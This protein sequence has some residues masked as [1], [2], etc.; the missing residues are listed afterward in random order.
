MPM[1]RRLLL[2][3]PLLAAPITAGCGS[4]TGPDAIASELRAGERATT[5][6]VAPAKV[7]CTGM[8]PTQCLQVRESATAPWQYFYDSIEGF[9]WEPG[10]TYTLAVAIREIPNPPADGSS[11]AYR[12]LRVVAKTGG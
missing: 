1:F 11:R 2:A 6:Y 7:A 3:V 9:S 4:A 5:L 10:Y 8:Y 12:L